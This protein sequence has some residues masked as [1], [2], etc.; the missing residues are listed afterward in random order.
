[1]A[2][3][4][5]HDEALLI[6]FLLGQCD[7]AQGRLVQGR[8]ERDA[9][10]A[11][12]LED[13]RNT[14]AALDLAVEHEPPETLVADVLA[15]VRSARQTD[16]LLA[17]EQLSRRD[18]IRP[19]FSLREFGAI[20]GVLLLLVSIFGVS[21]RE[22][23]RRKDLTHCAAQVARM[24]SAL[25]TYANRHD[26][27]L[28]TATASGP[29]WLPTASQPAASNSTALFRLV[30]AG[31]VEPPA[32]QCPAVGGSSFVVQAGMTD[33]PRPESISY[34]YQHSLGPKGLWIED[35]RL[36]G[37]KMSMVILADSTPVFAGG[38]FRADRVRTPVSDNHGRMGQNVLY[39]DMHVDFKRLPSV[40]VMGDNIYLAGDIQDYHGEEAPTSLT[41]T[42]L[43]PAFSED[44][45]A[46]DSRAPPMPD[47]QP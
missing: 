36:L 22:A 13:L 20:A 8:L 25:L 19:T 10:F 23:R 33:F 28:P 37:V 41:D 46:G 16:A 42:F 2:E 11:R 1:M 27:H 40:G 32:F 17:R 5:A 9:A 15:R 29:R 3:D 44:D 39:L 7:E 14:L 24:G 6:D 12:T 45:R 35:R 38:R 30:K 4:K 47:Q 26:G 43:L 18:V 21:Y 31:Y 34:S